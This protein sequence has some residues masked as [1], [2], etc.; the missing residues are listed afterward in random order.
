MLNSLPRRVRIYAALCHLAGFIW[1]LAT[2]LL[3][4]V[5]SSSLS[6]FGILSLISILIPC[7]TW[8]STRRLHDFVDRSG[9]EAVNAQLSV[10]LYTGCS[11][12]VTALACGMKMNMYTASPLGAGA[13]MLLIFIVPFGMMV[14]QIV[15]IVA[16]VQAL[17]GNVLRYP[18]II[19]FI[20]DPLLPL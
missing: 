2:A 16:A 3:I 7:L 11:V 6:Y 10:L 5:F 9:R 14:Y 13:A 15:S 1:L 12:F 20:P 19:R 4:S 8:L 18:L 17:R